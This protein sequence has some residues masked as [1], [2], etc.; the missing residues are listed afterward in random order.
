MA[1]RRESE[2]AALPLSEEE[3]FSYPATSRRGSRTSVRPASAPTL[4]YNLRVRDTMTRKVVT[5]LAD[6]P[7]H[8]VTHRMRAFHVS[9]LPVVDADGRLVGII[10]ET[11]VARVLGERTGASPLDVLLHETPLPLALQ[12]EAMLN[13]YRETLSHVKVR[14][15]M[16]PAPIS[17][18]AGDT[19]ETAIRRMKEE[20]VNRLPVLE[21]G[22]L[23]GL[24]ARQD[25]LSALLP[26]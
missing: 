9:G 8:E 21:E 1:R 7:L 23:V 24:I 2:T 22:R 16:T 17:I 10:T 15:V 26:S 19:L 20:R 18:G 11:D 25:V 4:V 3:E 14:D 12:D 5:V 6:S 13:R